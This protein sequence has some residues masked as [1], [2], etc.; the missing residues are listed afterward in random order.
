MLHSKHHVCFSYSQVYKLKYFTNFDI[1]NMGTI[2]YFIDF[3]FAQL[4]IVHLQ[5]KR[6]QAN[7]MDSN[8]QTAANSLPKIN[9]GNKTNAYMPSF[10]PSAYNQTG[11]LQ[12]LGTT[13][14]STTAFLPN[15]NQNIL[16]AKPSKAKV[17]ESFVSIISKEMHYS[18]CDLC[19]SF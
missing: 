1:V 18:E 11:T 5:R 10:Q 7:A 19:S 12:K 17:S 15:L 9:H 8:D 14:T 3:D 6:N 2:I 13:S 4:Y 16:N